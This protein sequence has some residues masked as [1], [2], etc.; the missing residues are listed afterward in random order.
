M[1]EATTEARGWQAAM[2][3]H[4]NGS[5]ARTVI[6]RRRHVGPLRIQKPF[7]PGDGACHVYLLHPPGGLVGGDA[8]DVTVRVGSRAR[9]LVTTP[10]ATKVYR[11]AGDASVLR[12]TLSVA[13]GASLEWLPQEVLLFGGSITRLSTHIDLHRGSKYCGWEVLGLGRPRSGD[14][15]TR[16]SV[17]QRLTLAVDGIPVL[18]ER[19]EWRAGEAVLYARWGLQEKSVA[20]VMHLYPADA[21]VLRRARRLVDWQDDANFGV[22]LTDGLLSAR[23]LASD[24]LAAREKLAFLW[25]GLRECVFGMRAERPRIWAT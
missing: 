11:S 9:S 21:D 24:A 12:Q 19:N 8:L 3:L 20:G 2:D 17:D 23:V 16:G 5:G 10:A 4:F 13:A 7:Y 15:F 14:H 25:A 6:T 18:I 1:S 22:T